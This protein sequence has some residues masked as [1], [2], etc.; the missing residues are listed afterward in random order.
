MQNIMPAFPHVHNTGRVRFGR[1]AASRE[2]SVFR[3]LFPRSKSAAPANHLFG[4]GA[5][6]ACSPAVFRRTA[7]RTA[8]AMAVAPAQSAEF[9][10]HAGVPKGAG[11]DL[12]LW[13]CVLRTELA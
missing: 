12:I 1:H 4:F 9:G 3:V 11:E 2:G 7:G 10:S 6:P 5:G 8:D 13:L